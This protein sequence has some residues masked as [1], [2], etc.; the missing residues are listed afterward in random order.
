MKAIF[1]DIDGVLCT[2]LSFWINRLLRQPIERQR[3]DPLALFWLRRLTR[4]TKAV[5][6]LSSSWRDGLTADDP[7]SRAAMGNL[8]ARLDRNGT[9][10]SDATPLALGGDK[11]M[12]IAAWLHCHPCEQYVI[13]D[14][15][16]CFSMQPAV[17]THWVPIP[18]SRG[19]RH[20]EAVAAL[21]LLMPQHG[22]DFPDKES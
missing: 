13:L 18:D 21:H 11:G 6:V 16:D 20:R 4:R 22:S 8:F 9:P 7:F 12:E 19:L 3:F 17:R 1:L 5:V 10:I 15:N 2:P 14:D